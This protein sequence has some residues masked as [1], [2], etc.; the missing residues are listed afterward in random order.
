MKLTIVLGILAAFLA[1]A[2]AQR[3]DG[4]KNTAP[5]PIQGEQLPELVAHDENGDT[6]SLNQRLEGKH[7]VIVFGCLT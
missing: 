7:G 1:P 2:Q 4:M 6:F 5:L 3:G